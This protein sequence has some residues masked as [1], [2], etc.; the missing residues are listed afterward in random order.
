MTKTICK[1]YILYTQIYFWRCGNIGLGGKMP[2]ESS[3]IKVQ[4]LN[5]WQTLTQMLVCIVMNDSRLLI[6]CLTHI[7]HYYHVVLH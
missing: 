4:C 3:N 7:F 1:N 5:K 2:A 6:L